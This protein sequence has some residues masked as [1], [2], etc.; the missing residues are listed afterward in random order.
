MLGA[1]G[2]ALYPAPAAKA[3][4]GIGLGIAKRKSALVW[5]QIDESEPRGSLA[6]GAT[7]VLGDFLAITD[8][9]RALAAGLADGDVARG[10]ASGL[11]VRAVYAVLDISVS[12][13]TRA[14]NG[15]QSAGMRR[16]YADRVGAPSGS[17]NVDLFT[18]EA[19][20]THCCCQ[21]M[22]R[23]PASEESSQVPIAEAKSRRACGE[24]AYGSS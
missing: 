17:S 4:V 6:A 9:T 20:L 18:T 14:T 13:R 8:I 11:G 16:G 22:R 21:R 5:Q 15:R 1:V 23:G 10:L 24:C 2:G 7:R 3:E 12:H 19:G